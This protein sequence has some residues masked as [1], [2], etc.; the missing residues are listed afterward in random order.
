MMKNLIVLMTLCLF[1]VV[2][3]NAQND[4]SKYDF[5]NKSSAIFFGAKAGLNY[6]NIYDTEGEA[7]E[8]D[9]KFGFAGGIF[10]SIPIGDFLG[11]QPEVLFSQKGYK[12]KGILFDEAYEITR[13]SNYIDVPLLVSVRPVSFL[14]ILAGPQYSFLLSQKNKVVNGNTSVEQKQ[15]FDNESL[16]KNTV[17]FTGGVD[18]NVRHLVVGARVGWD[19]FKNNG[20]NDS[21]TTP[22]YKNSWVQLTLGY[23]M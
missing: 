11:I 18:V 8:Y 22:R 3:V 1:V 20:N 15:E 21:Q 23:R 4:N 6:S 17:C 5:D 19:L 2:G 14:S 7:F 9:P 16:R 13:T 12:A 10:V